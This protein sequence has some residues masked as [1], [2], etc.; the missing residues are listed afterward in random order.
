M[1]P[2]RIELDIVMI[3]QGFKKLH[4]HYFWLS[5]LKLS[6]MSGILLRGPDKKNEV[7][8]VCVVLF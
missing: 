6:F 2:I 3:S 4:S 1:K 8:I 5:K 7:M